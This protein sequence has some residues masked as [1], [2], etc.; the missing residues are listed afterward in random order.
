MS[1]IY[2]CGPIFSSG[3]VQTVT[4]NMQL[5]STIFIRYQNTALVNRILQHKFT[6][7]TLSR[8]WKFLLEVGSWSHRI[9]TTKMSSDLFPQDFRFWWWDDGLLQ[10]VPSR[11]FFWPFGFFVY[12]V[13]TFMPFL[14][15]IIQ[16]LL[17]YQKKKEKN[18][19]LQSGWR[20]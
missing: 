14:L 8:N 12:I 4:C 19:L 17:T 1:I 5:Y 16:S 2:W 10:F 11:C 15:L 18:G 3:F 20:I 6:L 9:W 13:Y 7:N